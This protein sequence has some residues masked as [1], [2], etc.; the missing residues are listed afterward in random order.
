MFVAGQSVRDL[1]TLCDR[2]GR[3]NGGEDTCRLFSLK[4]ID[5]VF[6]YCRTR[7]VEHIGRTEILTVIE[8]AST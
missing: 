1:R 2:L 8:I 6:D 4:L 5:D 3:Y 7:V